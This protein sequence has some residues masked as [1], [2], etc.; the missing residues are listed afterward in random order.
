M[1]D[2]TRSGSQAG[3]AGG[4]PCDGLMPQ[5]TFSTF[6]LSLSSSAMVHLGEVPDPDTGQ[7]AMNLPMAKHTI[8]ILCM[9]K[10][11]TRDALDS[12][13]ARLIDGILFELRMVYVRKSG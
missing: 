9:L 10:Q 11:K 8:D 3:K 2:E 13:E 1:S 6:I 5:V 12:D 7:V 4:C